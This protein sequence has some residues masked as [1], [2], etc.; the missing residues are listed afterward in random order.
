MEEDTK[1]TDAK[2]PADQQVPTNTAHDDVIE[3]AGKDETAEVKIEEENIEHPKEE[4]VIIQET[5]PPKLADIV[6]GSV[7][8]E[9]SKHP[10]VNED[11]DSSKVVE[12]I[13]PSDDN[14]EPRVEN[15]AELSTLRSEQHI[16]ETE[17]LK[18]EKEIPV[19]TDTQTTDEVVPATVNVHDSSEIIEVANNA[20]HV[21]V[22]HHEQKIPDGTSEEHVEHTPEEV[23]LVEDSKKNS[24][25]NI[26]VPDVPEQDLAIDVTTKD[27]VDSSIENH[28]NVVEKLDDVKKISQELS[29]D[30]HGAINKESAEDTAKTESEQQTELK[31]EGPQSDTLQNTEVNVEEVHKDQINPT[32]ELVNSEVMPDIH[33]GKEQ[34]IVEP[35]KYSEVTDNIKD[36]RQAPSEHG[37]HDET[38]HETTQPTTKLPEEKL[39]DNIDQQESNVPAANIPE[40]SSFE[41]QS[42][43]SKDEQFHLTN[44]TNGEVGQTEM[45]DSA[46]DDVLEE[47]TEPAEQALVC[48]IKLFCLYCANVDDSMTK[49][50]HILRKILQNLLRS[51]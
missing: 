26:K 29:I 41:E 8:E 28:D 15:A 36:E 20:E 24:D 37:V 1:V 43:E 23:Q 49:R 11:K 45:H 33:I 12:I 39:V 7:V 42:R 50:S 2:G 31:V 10:E 21:P 48:V 27:A 51:L 18:D 47:A 32:R 35:V 13:P 25:T 46:L 30:D 9:A 5:T 22:L 14:E 19:L 38:T 34:E 17:V 44:E 16:A 40:T 4:E 6:E 3:H